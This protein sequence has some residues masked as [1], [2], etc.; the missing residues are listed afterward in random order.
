MGSSS[1]IGCVDKALRAL[2]RLG[3]IGAAGQSLTRL[4]NDL[5]LDKTSLYRTLQALGSRGF[6]EKDASGNYHLGAT[7]RTLADSSL[8]DEGLRGVVHG[9]LVDLSVK[10][11]ETCHLGV[12]AGDQIVYVDKAG[13]PQRRERMLS[14]IGWRSQAVSTALGRAI[15]C[16]KFLDFQSFVAGITSTIRQCTVHTCTS[17][18]DLW[19]KLVVARTLGFAREEQENELGFT[20]VAMALLRAGR[21]VGAVSITVP[22]ERLNESRIQDLIGSLRQCMEPCLPPGLSLQKPT[23]GGERRSDMRRTVL[24][25]SGRRFHRGVGEGRA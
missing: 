4:A 10:T 13:P 5:D 12:L 8:R 15:L 21:V 20:S 6:V 11:N 14:A 9:G 3:E 19:R 7:I 25:F 23:H 18:E 17:P 2:Q 22:H 1:P 16:H 24:P